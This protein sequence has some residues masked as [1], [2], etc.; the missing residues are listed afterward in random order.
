MYNEKLWKINILIILIKTNL[1][2]SHI[3]TPLNCDDYFEAEL[4]IKVKGWIPPERKPVGVNTNCPHLYLYPFSHAHII[5]QFLSTPSFLHYYWFTLP[6]TLLLFYPCFLFP[7]I[8]R[9][10]PNISEEFVSV[11]GAVSPPR[12]EEFVSVHGVRNLFFMLWTLLPVM[13]SFV[14]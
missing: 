3:Q 2:K 13:Y 1:T 7:L 12:S 5:I 8:L 14:L 11:H 9:H 10:R 6:H 4:L